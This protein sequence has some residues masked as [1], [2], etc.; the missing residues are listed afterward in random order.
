MLRPPPGAVGS[1]QTL[2]C[3]Q[4]LGTWP[5]PAPAR[6]D[7]AALL[8][9]IPAW[10]AAPLLTPALLSGQMMS[11]HRRR[12]SRTVSSPCGPATSA[13]SSTSAPR[14]SWEGKEGSQEGQRCPAFFWHCPELPSSLGQWFWVSG[15][16]LAMMGR[17][18]G[19]DGCRGQWWA[20]KGSNVGVSSSLMADGV[21]VS[22]AFPPQG[23]VWRSPHVHGE[24][25]RAQAGGQSD[26]ETGCQGQGLT[27]AGAGGLLLATVPP[28]SGMAKV[29]GGS[30]VPSVSL[31]L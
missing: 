21:G 23:Q 31:V 30:V 22:P 27:D 10:G 18:L 6:F 14:T 1:R 13:P 20:V 24:A 11:L 2:I 29:V 4:S 15:T 19:Q 17:C 9:V 26:P 16:S 8:G 5:H 28:A 7:W 12:P 3:N 25:D